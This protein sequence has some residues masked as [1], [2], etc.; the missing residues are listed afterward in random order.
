MKFRILLVLILNIFIAQ[1]SMT[2]Q[3]LPADVQKNT[4]AIYAPVTGEVGKTYFYCQNGDKC[5][6]EQ[7]VREY[8]KAK[9]YSVMR[10]EYSFWKGMF[11]LSFLDELYPAKHYTF[12]GKTGVFHDM[13]L[14]KEQQAD[15]IKKEAYI[16][17]ADLK[18]F[19]NLQIKKHEAGAYIRDLDEWEFEGYKNPTEYF[20]SPIVQEF[21]TKIDNK[22]FYKMVTRILQDR[23]NNTV[24]TPDYIIWNKKELIFV[25]VKREKE[26]LRE[27]QITWAEFLIN[28]R[29]PY[30]VIRVHGIGG[31][32]GTS[33]Y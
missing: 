33:K 2:Q 31:K 20:K 14:Y 3:I 13:S 23:K 32:K 17:N 24:G 29:I 8:Y 5:S 7:V 10:A 30:V 16:K 11:I 28:N 4:E 15:L 12:Y 26:K 1:I 25:E 27:D 21:L 19:I 22:I 6:T 18:E 9:G